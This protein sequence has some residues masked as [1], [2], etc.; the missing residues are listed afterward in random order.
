MHFISLC[1]PP[2]STSIR[3]S[4]LDKTFSHSLSLAHSVSLSSLRTQTGMQHTAANFE[5]KKVKKSKPV[6]GFLPTSFPLGL[7]ALPSAFPSTG[8]TRCFRGAPLTEQLSPRPQ[9]LE[10]MT[11]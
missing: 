8:E 11:M 9:R 5:E 2:F 6:Q 10:L 1:F 7:V 4:H 3:F